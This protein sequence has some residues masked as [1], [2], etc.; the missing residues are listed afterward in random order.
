M[1]EPLSRSGRI[2]VGPPTTF[3]NAFPTLEDAVIEYA[4]G[5]ILR[6]GKELN[7]VASMKR[8]GGQLRCSN[9]SC[10]RGGYEFDFDAH[11]MVR[12]KLVSRRLRKTCQGDEGTPKGRKQGRQCLN[13]IDA[14]L[15]LVYKPEFM[16]L[17]V[18]IKDKLAAL[19]LPRCPGCL[20]YQPALLDGDGRTLTCIEHQFEILPAG[21]LRTLRAGHHWYPK[22]GEV[23]SSSGDTVALEYFP[24]SDEQVKSLL[25]GNADPALRG[26]VDQCLAE[27]IPV[28][29]PSR[30]HQHMTKAEGRFALSA[31]AP[32]DVWKVCS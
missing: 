17:R 25:E 9:S 12:N 13:S 27:F 7:R 11:D 16:P 4:E 20:G 29:Q 23:L 18:R 6:Q 5:D 32:S 1:G 21:K 19:E 26:L 24:V 28:I 2:F 22:V 15:R 31:I 8:V 14:R 10:Y 30:P 3:E